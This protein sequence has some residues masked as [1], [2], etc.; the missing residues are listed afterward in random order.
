[1]F[2]I[3]PADLRIPTPLSKAR[4]M[5]NDKRLITLPLVYWRAFRENIQNN[6]QN[7]IR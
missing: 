7:M 4:A 1:M 6:V 2:L 3:G 5:S